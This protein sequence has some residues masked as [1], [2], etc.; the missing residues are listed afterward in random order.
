MIICLSGFVIAGPSPA[1]PMS[2]R[3]DISVP[4]CAYAP[5][6]QQLLQHFAR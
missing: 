3:N 2:S 5:H 6:Q 1:I 4:L